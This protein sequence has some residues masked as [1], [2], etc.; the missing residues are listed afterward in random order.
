M[1][2]VTEI[3]RAGQWAPETATDSLCLNYDQRYRRR[4]RYK[5]AGGTDLL[6]D[7]PTATVLLPGDGLKLDDGSM[8]LVDAA[9]E[10]LME[11]TSPDATTLIRL[12]WHIGNRHLAAQLEESRI[13]IREDHVISSMLLGLGATVRPF[14][15]TFSPESGAY[16]EHDGPLA[17]LAQLHPVIHKHE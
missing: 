17:H 4:L 2:L 11:V 5:A 15:G 13:V 6:L 8:V 10:A 12:A 7:L 16:H 1:K 3:L 9:P 14:Q